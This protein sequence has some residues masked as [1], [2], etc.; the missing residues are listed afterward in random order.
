[1]NENKFGIAETADDVVALS[2]LPIIAVSLDALEYCRANKIQVTH[3]WELIDMESL[4]DR[5]FFDAEKVYK[6]WASRFSNRSD[7]WLEDAAMHRFH[8]EFLSHATASLYLSEALKEII[9]KNNWSISLAPSSGA[10]LGP[11]FPNNQKM[12]RKNG[13][14]KSFFNDSH[15]IKIKRIAPRL[16]ADIGE[17][18]YGTL[19]P[20]PKINSLLKKPGIDLLIT[21]WGRDL[22]RILSRDKISADLK[23]RNISFINLVWRKNSNEEDIF[24][25][26]RVLNGVAY[27]PSLSL[28]GISII[29]RYVRFIFKSVIPRFKEIDGVRSAES[30][31]DKLLSNSEFRA[32]FK[33]NI[34]FAYREAF[35]TKE[36]MEFIFGRAKPKLLL[37]SDSGGVSARTELICAKEHGIISISTP[38]GYQAYSMQ[39]YNYIADLITTHGE[40]S[41]RMIT[42][43][44]VL[45][46]KVIPIGNDF[47]LKPPVAIRSQ[48]PRITIATRSWGG[49]WSNYSSR[50]DEYDRELI[51]FILLAQKNNWPVVLK[52]HP[53][54]DYHEYYDL[55]AKRFSNVSH[56]S[57]GWKPDVF[58]EKTDILVCVGEMPSLFIEALY[59]QIP[60]VFV[61]GVMT[62]TQ[63]KL[64]YNY[65]GLGAV[66]PSGRAAIQ[67]I[68]E[69]IVDSEAFTLILEKQRHVALSYQ[70]KGTTEENLSEIIAKHLK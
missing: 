58:R 56:T 63:K 32:S 33:Y 31:L 21:G 41:K 38:H 15:N 22:S 10:Y 27:G 14:L 42:I 60:I 46:E 64:H 7:S 36:L 8:V 26:D 35:I 24:V 54:G 45:P 19:I 70:T 12:L 50:H 6:E 48:F 51:D 11:Y 47:A 25:R 52:S 43:T 66:V 44:G 59:M 17:Y 2:G 49:L 4:N 65:D 20:K 9:K 5:A 3:I 40:A 13:L 53:N 61:D 57:K 62:K 18:F 30:V 37:G 68:K 16:L 23:N 34:F 1:M 67:K 28:F 39:D 69:I 55:L 29:W